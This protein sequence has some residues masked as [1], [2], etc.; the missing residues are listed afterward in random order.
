MSS[1]AQIEYV[2][3][4]DETH[5]SA[6]AVLYDRAFGA[7]LGIAIRS[8]RERLEILERSLVPEFAIAAIDGE[9]L[10]GLAGLHSPEGSLTAG[11]SPREL[12]GRLGPVR[13]L[14]AI[15]ILSLLERK[16][17]PGELLM[18]GIAVDES[19][20]GRGI[21]S[22]L[23]RNVVEYATA[24]GYRSVRLDVIDTNPAAK[25]L[26]ERLGFVTVRHES[27]PFLA[28]LLGFGGSTT[29]AYDVL[30]SAKKG[31]R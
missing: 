21:G 12:I 14:R 29:M 27:F 11:L 6:A 24:N 30:Q 8:Q 22:G 7:K 5:F 2:L 1:G 26:Y 9:R 18:D 23:L 16:P 31:T 25:R 19:H 17:A 13:G 15:A 4:L 20:R 3:G 10:V 28:W